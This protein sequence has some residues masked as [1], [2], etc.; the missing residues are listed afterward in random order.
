MDRAWKNAALFCVTC[1]LDVSVEKDW[2]IWRKIAFSSIEPHLV[3]PFEV[4]EN[5][6]CKKSHT[7]V[8]C[9]SIVKCFAAALRAL[10]KVVNGKGV[11]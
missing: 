4:F 9:I 1:P 7:M 6:G 2:V 8:K 3:V 10:A 11:E 5:L